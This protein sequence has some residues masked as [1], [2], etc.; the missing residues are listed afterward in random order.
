[1]FW[2]DCDAAL[3][4]MSVSLCF[5]EHETSL[6]ERVNGKIWKHQHKS[7][8][9]KRVD[10]RRSAGFLHHFCHWQLIWSNNEEKEEFFRLLYILTHTSRTWECRA[11]SSLNRVPDEGWG[12]WRAT[13]ASQHK[14][15]HSSG[16]RFSAV[17]AADAI[18]CRFEYNHATVW[19]SNK[20]AN[21]STTHNIEKNY[22]IKEWMTCDI[23]GTVADEVKTTT[24]LT[25]IFHF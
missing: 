15:N 1:M 11:R 17:A 6:R 22:N 3:I 8:E 19:C 25:R 5:Q 7:S 14:R 4:Y 24:L 16:L 21:Y 23:V 9:E 13:R 18:S 10:I 2:V 12:R 20:K